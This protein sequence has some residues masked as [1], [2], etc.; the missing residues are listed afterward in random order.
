[1]VS[2]N[3]PSELESSGASSE[4]TPSGR[5]WLSVA[6]VIVTLIGLVAALM[7]SIDALVLAGN[8]DAEL[9]CS[10]NSVFD[11]AAV[12]ASEQSKIFGIPNA[13]LGMLLQGGLVAI[14]VALFG[15]ARMPRWYMAALNALLVVS[16]LYGHWLLYQSTFVIHALCL[17]CLTLLASTVLALFIVTHWNL[18]EGNLFLGAGADA[19][20]AG[21]V[22]GGWLAI[23]LIAWVAIIVVAEVAAWLL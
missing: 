23:A 14:A 17:W 22:R 16:A 9:A 13:F 10:I 7:L 1:M 8:P 12:G 21:F 11:C 19:K 3:Q 20:A 6:M 18:L 4:L 2:V 5:R 15:G